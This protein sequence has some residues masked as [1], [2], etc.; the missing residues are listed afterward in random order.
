[1]YAKDFKDNIYIRMEKDKWLTIEPLLWPKICENL[2]SRDIVNLSSTC[3]F[4]WSEL[5]RERILAVKNLLWKDDYRNICLKTNPTPVGYLTKKLPFLTDPSNTQSSKIIRVPAQFKMSYNP[6]FRKFEWKGDLDSSFNG[7]YCILG[8]EYETLDSLHGDSL[9]LNFRTLIVNDVRLDHIPILQ[10]MMGMEKNQIPFPMLK[11]GIAI[12]L[13]DPVWVELWGSNPDFDPDFDPHP[14]IKITYLL[15]EIDLPVDPFI[16]YQYQSMQSIILNEKTMEV[17]FSHGI[18]H[19]LI[20]TEPFY[21]GPVEAVFRF[22]VYIDPN[23]GYVENAPHKRRVLQLPEYKSYR[24]DNWRVFPLRGMKASRLDKYPSGIWSL[25]FL[26]LEN[27]IKVDVSVI[28]VNCAVI[29]HGQ[30]DHPSM[31]G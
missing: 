20:H 25:Y 27:E 10:K 1:M 24:V 12:P 16:I 5:E 6:F 11:G 15:K 28:S 8:I 18:S 7:K 13:H 30:L 2:K 19:I 3:L 22:D 14:N 29:N 21:D 4:L 26:H 9:S 17:R 31:T 23:R